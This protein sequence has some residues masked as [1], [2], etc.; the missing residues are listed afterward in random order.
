MNSAARRVFAHL[1]QEHA[2]SYRAIL[3]TFATA[4]EQ[5]QIHLRPAEILR[6]MTD[7]GSDPA[8]EEEL[9]ARLQQLVE[10]GNLERTPDR[11]AAAT[12]EDFY[13]A[14]Y[15]YQL[16]EEGEAAESALRHFEE[17]LHRPGELQTAALRDIIEFLDAV[18]GLLGER[19]R[20]ASKLHAEFK[21][22][23][24]R[25][26]E[27]TQRAQAFMRGLHSTIE[28]HGISVEAFLEYK[29]RLLEYLERFLGELVMAS[30]EISNRILALPLGEEVF[31]LLAGQ[32]LIDS[33]DDSPEL[34]EQTRIRWAG[35]WSGFRLWFLGAASG[36]SQAEIL[37]Q[38]A[39][40]AIPALL[41]TV[42]TINDR[43]VSRSDRLADWRT[44]ALWFAE[45]P[46]DHAAHR[47]WRSAFG[48]APARHL[49]INQETLELRDQLD[50][51]PRVSWL[52]AEPVRVNP[53]LRASG[54]VTARGGPNRVIDTAKE[55]EYLARLAAEENAQLEAAKR[56]L[57]TREPLL[58]SHFETLD[59]TAFELL[60]DLLG[61]AM[62]ARMDPSRPVE[63]ASTDGSLTVRLDPFQSHRPARIRTA[64]GT[65]TGPDALVHI[66]ES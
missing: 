42:H 5:F 2:G 16:S 60:L 37:R 44:L 8:D 28:L 22:M 6:G 31:G 54:R 50:E 38:R 49:L 58:L 29:N 36:V 7:A 55:R 21:A 17:V 56:A 24:D 41:D 19:P 40:E 13:R 4:R 26:E 64:V 45:A 15:L 35:Q 18:R 23:F 63:A 12:V 27:L 20:D 61:Q 39:R 43:R 25:F 52:E 9:A 32:S 62:N 34:L 65:I 57:V 11:V 30:S 48:M 59:A 1:S 10:W 47:L 66:S 51:S 3:E 14:R 33:I 53:R 46:S